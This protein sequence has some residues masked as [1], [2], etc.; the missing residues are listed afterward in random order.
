MMTVLS[1]GSVVRACMYALLFLVIFE[2]FINFSVHIK[3]FEFIRKYDLFNLDISRY[4]VNLNSSNSSNECDWI[5]NSSIRGTKIILDGQC[6]SVRTCSVSPSGLGKYLVLNNSVC[7]ILSWKNDNTIL[8]LTRIKSSNKL[9]W[10]KY[11]VVC[12]SVNISHKQF[13]PN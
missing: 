12:L 13:Q 11:F 8:K 10:S 7:N 5:S 1:H 9:S 2:L 4:T 3:T 6:K